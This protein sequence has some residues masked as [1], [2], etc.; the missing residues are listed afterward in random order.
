MKIILSA[1]LF[2][3]LAASDHFCWAD[4]STGDVIGGDAF[5][6]GTFVKLHDPIGDIGTNGFQTDNIYAFHEVQNF[7]LPQDLVLD[8]STVLANTLVDSH[9]VF[10]DPD[11]TT[12]QIGYVEFAGEILGFT[13][14]NPLLISTHGILGNPT[15]NYNTIGFIGLEEGDIVEID[16]INPNRLLV[17]WVA[18]SPGDHIRVLTVPGKAP[19]LL[20]DVNHDCVVNLLDVEPFVDLLST[21][22]FQVEA[23]LNQDGSVNLLDVQ[24]F[25]DVLS[26]S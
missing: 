12:T 2:F 4:I 8:D 17:N 15:A 11:I 21:G 9:M 10:F 22:Q 14:S 13:G 18:A 6:A 5:G 19:I 24:P 16:P 23:D 3:S 26:G 1:T 7:A 20:G 25:V